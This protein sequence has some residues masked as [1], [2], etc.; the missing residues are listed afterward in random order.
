MSQN[1]IYYIPGEVY[2]Y[3][4]ELTILSQLTNESTSHVVMVL[5]RSEASNEIELEDCYLVMQNR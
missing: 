5:G 2:E 1:Y 3:M 4:L